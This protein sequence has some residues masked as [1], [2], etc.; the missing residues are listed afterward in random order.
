MWRGTW[1]LID[2]RCT[3]G[4]RPRY[5]VWD[6]L[7]CLWDT[8]CVVRT[9]RTFAKYN[10]TM[11]AQYK[12]SRLQRHSKCWFF[13]SYDFRVT[14]ILLRHHGAN[15]NFKLT[16]HRTL[17]K[18]GIVKET[19]LSWPSW[20][21]L[22]EQNWTWRITSRRWLL[23]P[24][25]Y[26]RMFPWKMPPPQKNYL[27]ILWRLLG[28]HKEYFRL[29]LKWSSRGMAVTSSWKWQSGHY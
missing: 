14:L 23:P 6:F 16:I 19:R 20:V 21:F 7:S 3:T 12:R 5:E 1:Q 29:A 17:R 22:Y 2:P 8:D 13:N 26:T 11:L 28:R 4:N 27:P 9:V 25:G 24:Q 15:W 18:S 10:G